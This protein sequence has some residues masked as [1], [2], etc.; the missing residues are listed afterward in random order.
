[1]VLIRKAAAPAM[2]A[3]VLVSG[4]IAG[5][6]HLGPRPVAPNELVAQRTLA[7]VQVNE[8]AWPR[9][10]WWQTYG[11][12]QLDS[13]IS[14]ALAGSPTLRVAQARLREAQ[15]LVTGASAPRLPNTT[16]DAQATSQRYS[17][18]GLYP[19][20]FAG[21]WYTDGRVALDFSYDLDFWGHNRQVLESARAN[22]HAAEADHAAA[23]LAL[24][25]AVAR[26]YFNFSLQFALL[27]IAN[28]SLVQ[29]NAILDLTQ[30]RAARGLE[31]IA[32]VKQSEGTVALTRAGVQYQEAAIRLVRAQLGALAGAGP[33]RGADLQR[34]ALHAPQKVELPSLLPAELLGRRPDLVAQRWRVEAA[35]R[36]VSA[37][38]AAFYPNVNLAAFA[39]FQAI[40]LGSLFNGGS[41]IAG[42]GPAV[43]L[44]IF[45][46]RKLRGALQSQQA[47]YDYAVAQYNQ[48]LIDA[49]N[50]VANV[51]T[52]WDGLVKESNEARIAEGAAQSAYAITRERYGAGLDNYLTVL[53]SENQVFF[54][55]AIRAQLLARELNLTAD[56]VRALG[57]GYAGGTPPPN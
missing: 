57:G 50:D 39:G 34:P 25:V 23:R 40:G 13:L 49:V 33:D 28:A 14:E 26:A 1:M 47:Q 8:E 4:C 20:P 56:L 44:P 9:D 37:A 30:Q 21:N 12:P 43:S 27:D 32:R 38:E 55:Q 46:R 6:D 51:V 15:A 52:N 45:N 36:G 22:V 19:P 18:N 29:Q 16:V 42:A 24:T 10:N 54:T 41:G 53:S 35:M 5:R 7:A 17:A 3:C 31:N 11:D 2:M 48:T